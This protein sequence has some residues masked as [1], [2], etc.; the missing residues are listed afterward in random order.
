[1][2]KLDDVT[3]T[4]IEKKIST[5]CYE[6]LDEKLLKLDLNKIQLPINILEFD[7]I[8][9]ENFQ[10]IEYRLTQNWRYKINDLLKK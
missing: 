3:R 7:K 1:L 2:L 4:E 8:L 9:N 10:K 6:Y 5:L